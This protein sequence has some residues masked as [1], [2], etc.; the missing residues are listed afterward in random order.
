MSAYVP[1]IPAQNSHGE[2]IITFGGILGAGV[3]TPHT[4]R[5]LNMLREV[6]EGTKNFLASYLVTKIRN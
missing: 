6:V 2:R 3:Y 4:L 1:S 5:T